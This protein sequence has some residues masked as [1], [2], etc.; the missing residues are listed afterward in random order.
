MEMVTLIHI[1]NIRFYFKSV[2]EYFLYLQEKCRLKWQATIGTYSKLSKQHKKCI[3]EKNQLIQ[4]VKHISQLWEREKEILRNTEK[5]L[6]YYVSIL[7]KIK[8]KIQSKVHYLNTKIFL[9]FSIEND[10]K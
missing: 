10:E 5:E 3:M 1:N 2:T 4:N 8:Q 9:Y 7:I 6:N